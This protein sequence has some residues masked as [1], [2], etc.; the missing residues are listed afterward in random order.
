MKRD[1][2]CRLAECFKAI[3]NETRQ[4]I[5]ALLKNGEM[6]VGELTEFFRL[7][8]PTISY[9]L[10]VLRH[11]NLVNLHRIDKY[12]FYYLNQECVNACWQELGTRLKVLEAKREFDGTKN[13]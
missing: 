12:A 1:S 11:A 4:G 7:P 8:Q 3:A 9:H 2:C 6:S 10:T 5:L 13:E